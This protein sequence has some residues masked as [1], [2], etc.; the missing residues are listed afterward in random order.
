MKNLKFKTIKIEVYKIPNQKTTIDI[1]KL[2]L[3]E[4][5]GMELDDVLV[6]I[7]EIKDKKT[8]IIYFFKIIKQIIDSNDLNTKL[9][10][11][12]K[13]YRESEDLEEKL[14]LIYGIIEKN[15]LLLDDQLNTT[16]IDLEKK[17]E[18][19]THSNLNGINE[20]AK[21]NKK[22]DYETALKEYKSLKEEIRLFFSKI[23]TLYT[24]T[25]Q[26]LDERKR[27]REDY[28]EVLLR[29]RATPELNTNVG[30]GNTFE[31]FMIKTGKRAGLLSEEDLKMR[32]I[33]EKK[34]QEFY[35]EQKKMK[36]TRGAVK[37]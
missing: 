18:R 28:I 4:L 1:T 21:L 11:Y 2:S 20:L 8:V 12:R 35:E 16:K 32:E 22:I 5:K 14:D 26:L 25:I 19:L 24:N 36:Q 37:N 31:E 29:L 7:N 23:C 34:A 9:I 15:N 27:A 10:Q 6:Y 17:L 33:N 3:D 30:I 13:K